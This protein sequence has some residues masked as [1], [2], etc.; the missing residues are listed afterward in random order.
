MLLISTPGCAARQ[1]TWELMSRT[2]TYPWLIPIITWY[3]KFPSSSTNILLI[4]SK[5]KLESR[6]IAV[7]VAMSLRNFGGKS[8]CRPHPRSRKY[9]RQFFCG[10][11][12]VLIELHHS[13]V[14]AWRQR[15]R[16]CGVIKSRISVA[17]CPFQRKWRVLHNYGISVLEQVGMSFKREFPCVLLTWLT[18]HA[19]ISNNVRSPM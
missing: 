16:S 3:R 4:K 11:Q 13:G 17:H 5:L 19:R 6:A 9:T 18:A 8:R 10:K 7:R 12:R 2:H 14:I 15:S 1:H